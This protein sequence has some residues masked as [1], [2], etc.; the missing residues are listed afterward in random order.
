MN[1]SPIDA[2]LVTT[3]IVGTVESIKQF[4]DNGFVGIITPVIAAA[5]G[6]LAGYGHLLGLNPIEGV[7]FALAAVGTHTLSGQIGG[8]SPSNPAV[9][10]PL[11]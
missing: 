6:F 8:T 5:L 11:Q 10:P 4:R 2:I 3:A 1:V 9:L 7:F